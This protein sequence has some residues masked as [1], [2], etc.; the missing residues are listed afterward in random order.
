[1]NGE[2]YAYFRVPPI[3]DHGTR[4][5]TRLPLRVRRPVPISRAD[6][7]EGARVIQAE[8]S[9]GAHGA[10]RGITVVRRDAGGTT[11]PPT[12]VRGGRAG[13]CYGRP[14]ARRGPGVHPGIFHRCA[15]GGPTVRDLRR[16]KGVSP[17]KQPYVRPGIWCPGAD[18]GGARDRSQTLVGTGGSLMPDP[19][20]LIDEWAEDLL[21]LLRHDHRWQNLAEGLMG[22]ERP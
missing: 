12:A 20:S 15:A 6:A 16:Q 9:R 3:D 17:E 13:R 14:R 21:A 7:Q 18:V 1:M 2:R 4:D 11:H 19:S 8:A 10:L 5:S 22:G